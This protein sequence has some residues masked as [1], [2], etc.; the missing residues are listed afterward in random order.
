MSHI[1]I[2]GHECSAPELS[3]WWF[4][5]RALLFTFLEKNLGPEIR[6]S[7]LYEDAFLPHSFAMRRKLLQKTSSLF[8]L[9]IGKLKTETTNYVYTVQNYIVTYS[10]NAKRSFW[11]KIFLS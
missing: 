2:Y 9:S 4:L 8:T 5:G 3:G 11:P 6:I 1:V 10:H 7:E